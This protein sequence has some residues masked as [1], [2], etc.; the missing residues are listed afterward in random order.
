MKKLLLAKWS[1]ALALAMAF[2]GCKD[3]LD[4]TAPYKEI[5]VVYC[6]LNKTDG[7]H[8]VRINK[9]YLGEGNA[10][11]YA[12]IPDSTTYTEAQLPASE[13]R[14]EKLN[15]NGVVVHT[16]QLRDTLVDHD[17]G[18][19]AG[20]QHKLY[21]F[22]G[23]LP[24]GKL[25]AEEDSVD[26]T[27][28]YTYRLVAIAKGNKVTA[29]TRLVHDWVQTTT[30][31]NL[32]TKIALKT[33]G[34]YV[35]TDIKWYTGVNSKRYD[36]YYRFQYDDV[37]INGGLT[38]HSFTT[39]F[40]TYITQTEGLQ[41]S[42][43]LNGESFYQ[44]VASNVA[45][46]SQSPGIQRRIFRGVDL[47]WAAG[48]VDLYTYLQL[49]NP[50]SG[51]VEERP[52]FSNISGGYGLMSSRF[53]KTIGSNDGDH[54]TRKWLENVSLDELLNG[55]YTGDRGFCNPFDANCQ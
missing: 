2:S 50:V 40:G 22:R 7:I 20:P 26:H 14:I 12:Q 47:I 10:Y 17:P 18:I 27:G 31:Q 8:W 42:V 25:A 23:D 29:S 1:I 49:A 24:D 30:T 34:G 16:Y 54:L 4:V 51:L 53:F 19:F 13:R 45:P 33:T 15:A 11:T 36:V 44:S 6:L 9:A 38:R 28:E 3:D 52:D 46:L 32:G 5:T 41:V 39:L 21:Y 48:G 37:D 35:T 43:P 55:Q